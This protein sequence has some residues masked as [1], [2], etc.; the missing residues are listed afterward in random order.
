MTPSLLDICDRF[1]M[2]SLSS[3]SRISS[4]ISLIV[5]RSFIVRTVSL[6]ASDISTPQVRMGGD[7]TALSAVFTVAW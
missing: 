2:D 1:L 3:A 7:V 5:L 6:G 4:V